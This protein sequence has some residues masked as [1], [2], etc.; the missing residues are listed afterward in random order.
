MGACRERALDLGC[1]TGTDAVGL[2]QQGWDVVGVDFVAQA[3]AKAQVRRV[4]AKSSARFVV[5]D[6]TR[7]DKAGVEG[8][9]L[10]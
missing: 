10:T 9:N 4:E 2:A 5:G 7:L 8:P 3:I 1:G 6:V